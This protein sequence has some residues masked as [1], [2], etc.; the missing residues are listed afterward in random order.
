ML[1]QIHMR[2]YVIGLRGAQ[3]RGTVLVMQ[4]AYCVFII[5]TAAH[6]EEALVRM[7]IF[8]PESPDKSD[9]ERNTLVRGRIYHGDIAR[10]AWGIRRQ[11]L[12]LIDNNAKRLHFDMTVITTVVIRAGRNG[13]GYYGIAVREGEIVMRGIAHG[14]DCG[15]TTGFGLTTQTEGEEIRTEAHDQIRLEVLDNL[16]KD[17][18]YQ[19]LLLGHYLIEAA[20]ACFDHYIL[21]AVKTEAVKALIIV[22]QLGHHGIEFLHATVIIGNGGIKHH[23][24]NSTGTQ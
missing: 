10:I 17:R 2:E 20:G 5:T 6:N 12:I 3:E 8:L 21:K 9:K 7:R 4:G 18:P 15:N 16:D 14:I 11:D 23:Y 22:R 1:G 13:I 24:S 19:G